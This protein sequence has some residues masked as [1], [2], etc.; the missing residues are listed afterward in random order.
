MKFFKYNSGFYFEQDING[1]KD[2]LPVCGERLQTL[3]YYGLT[4]EELT[5]F[6]TECRPKGMDRAVPMGKSMDFSL[7]WD[8][9]DLIRQLSRR[10][11]II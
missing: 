2:I 9:Y 1:L 5:A 4:R 7:T 6:F 11:T 8:G 3:T 10:V